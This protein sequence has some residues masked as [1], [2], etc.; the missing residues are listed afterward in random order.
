MGTICSDTGGGGI[1]EVWTKIEGD[2][3]NRVELNTNIELKNIYLKYGDMQ[4]RM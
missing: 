4:L 1:L 2:G 3:C